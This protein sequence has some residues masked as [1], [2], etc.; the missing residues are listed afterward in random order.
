M[1]FKLRECIIRDRDYYETALSLWHLFSKELRMHTHTY[2]VSLLLYSTYHVRIYILYTYI[3]RRALLWCITMFLVRLWNCAVPFQH[4]SRITQTRVTDIIKAKLL[5]VFY[6]VTK[7]PRLKGGGGKAWNLHLVGHS[8][9]VRYQ[10]NACTHVW[11]YITEVVDKYDSKAN[12]F[13]AIYQFF[14]ALKPPPPTLRTTS[15][16]YTPST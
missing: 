10:C 1:K 9:K 6:S 16:Q 3:P 5:G 12:I 8:N 14:V 13:T 2:V 4:G 11:V 15:L 7:H